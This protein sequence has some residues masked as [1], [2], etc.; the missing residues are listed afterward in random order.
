MR[1]THLVIAAAAL[2]LCA[3]FSLTSP[4]VRAATSTRQDAQTHSVWEGAYSDAQATRGQGLYGQECGTCHGQTLAGG[5]AAPPL[6]GTDFLKAWT[7]LALGELFERIRT[8]MPQDSP[9]RL[10]RQQ[11]A[12][13]LAHILK[14]NEFPAGEKELSRDAAALAQILI[15]DKPAAK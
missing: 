13:I 1:P 15:D 3:C 12:D 2:W 11:V 5:E 9:G 6:V 4:V 14:V 8:T 10:S 7:G